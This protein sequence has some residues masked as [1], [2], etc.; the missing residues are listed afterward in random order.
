MSAVAAG[1]ALVFPWREPPR[2]GEAREVAP[3]LFWAR[4]PL[5]FRLN[6]VNVW[7]LREEDGWTVIDTGCAT[8]DILAAWETLLADTMEGRPVVR[9]VATHGHVDH[10]GLTGWMVERFGAAFAGTFAEWVWARLSHTHN[11]PGAR[12]AHRD[13]LVRNG[14][15]SEDAE[16]LVESRSGFIDLSTPL[17]G[18]LEEIR[19][20]G[21]VRMGGR[22]W[23][24]I[25]TAGHAFE[26]AS[27]HC[28]ESGLLI[29]GDHLL[30]KISPVIAV[31]EML[32]NADPLGDFLASFPAFDGIA[33][34]ALILPSHGLPYYG[35]RER[36]GELAEHHRLRLDATWELLRSPQTGIALTRAMFPHIEGAANLG[37]ALGET[38]AHVNHLM[39][40]GIV[41]NVSG[42]PIPLF[43]ARQ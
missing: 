7:L 28:R 40:K 42:D 1:K 6:H 9:V 16:D 35:I 30:P 11:I 27:F 41:A 4:L 29:A 21:T 38:L 34:D 22:D 18:S 17:P 14:F 33:D 32:P 39:R 12:S 23:D 5:P 31:Y 24:V 20:G 8:P 43:Y 36:I 25:V 13:Y 3:G 2:T 15:P 37:F 26:H 19:Q 10:I